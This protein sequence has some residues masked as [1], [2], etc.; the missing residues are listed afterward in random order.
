[1][2]DSAIGALDKIESKFE[3]SSIKV[4][5]V[6][7]NRESEKLKDKIGGLSKASGH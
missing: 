5:Y 1:M 2:D 4:T 3:Q 6:G 7:L